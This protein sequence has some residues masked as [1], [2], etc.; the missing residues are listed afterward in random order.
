[1]RWWVLE[2]GV[3]AA[4]SPVALMYLLVNLY[5]AGVSMYFGGNLNGTRLRED[6]LD[7][8]ADLMAEGGGLPALYTVLTACASGAL[9]RSSGA[10]NT[11]QGVLLGLV[12]ATGIQHRNA[13]SPVRP[14]VFSAGSPV[15]A[16]GTIASTDRRRYP[17]RSRAR[18]IRRSI[19]SSY[20]RP[21]AAHSSA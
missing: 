3:V 10:P 13:S 16:A 19:R 15:R 9:T 6:F 2:L 7:P 12:S 8:F 20:G 5:A 18:E 1:M 17:W 11:V 14:R 21:L 4:L